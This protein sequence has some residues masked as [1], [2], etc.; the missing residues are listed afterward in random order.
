LSVLFDT[1]T[2]PTLVYGT[3]VTGLQAGNRVLTI[4]LRHYV[5]VIGMRG[6]FG[7][8]NI[9]D[10]P[11]TFAPAP[12]THPFTDLGPLGN[13]G[14]GVDLNTLDTNGEYYQELTAQAGTGANY[15]IPAAGYLEVKRSPSGTFVQQWYTTYSLYGSQYWRG[16]YNGVWGPWQEVGNDT[17]T[18]WVDVPASD[19]SMGTGWGAPTQFKYRKLGPKKVYIQIGGLKNPSLSVPT[20]GNIAN[21]KAMTLPS[22][23]SPTDDGWIQ[24]LVT[25]GSDRMTSWYVQS[26]GLWLG[27]IVTNS[28]WSTT[29]TWAPENIGVTGHYLL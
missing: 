3:L 20:H 6:G 8:D 15:P 29:V 4:K 13:L 12:H 26:G 18:N 7:W 19:Y 9:S 24:A 23:L 5:W 10:K 14:D 2:I 16:R 21:T 1:D 11:T 17:D 28:D 22:Y 25:D 27:A